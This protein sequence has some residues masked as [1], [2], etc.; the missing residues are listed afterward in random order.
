MEEE[1]Q[2]TIFVTQRRTLPGKARLV[3]TNSGSLGTIIN[4]TASG[5]MASFLVFFGKLWFSL[6]RPPMFAHG[7]SA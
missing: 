1:K 4:I 5:K 6:R 7:K 2:Y 3:Y